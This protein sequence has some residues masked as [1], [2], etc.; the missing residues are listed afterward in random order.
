MVI[1][2]QAVTMWHLPPIGYILSMQKEQEKVATLFAQVT[3]A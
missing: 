3:D 2:K 1:E